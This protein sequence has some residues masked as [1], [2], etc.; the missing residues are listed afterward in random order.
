MKCRSQ[1]KVT[2]VPFRDTFQIGPLA[3][4]R[5]LWRRSSVDRFLT[6]VHVPG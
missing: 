1:A 4:F 6:Q 3:A 2:M 5:A